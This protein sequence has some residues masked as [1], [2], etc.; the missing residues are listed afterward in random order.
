MTGHHTP[1]RN[2]VTEQPAIDRDDFT[3]L[4]SQVFDVP[5]H[6]LI[7]SPRLKITAAIPDGR[8]WAQIS[9]PGAEEAY[10]PVYPV[11]LPALLS[12]N[13]KKILALQF[14]LQD[15]RAEIARL[16][17]GEDDTPG[18]PAVVP[19][20]GQ[21]LRRFNEHSPERR[22][23]AVKAILDSR[24]RSYA[25][26][27]QNHEGYIEHLKTR[28]GRLQESAAADRRAYEAELEDAHRSA[29]T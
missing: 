11:G 2:P 13:V 9:V 8:V 24:E 1:G 18:D 7:A 4:I 27:V 12:P 19:T 28:I 29:G 21:W 23:A 5:A 20:P 10:V 26:F 6:L 17:A 14:E 15:A 25:C 3:Q 22:L 16:R